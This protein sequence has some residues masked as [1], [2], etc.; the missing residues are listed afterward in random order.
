MSTHNRNDAV[1][2]LRSIRRTL[3][4]GSIVLTTVVSLA[5]CSAGT[6]TPTSSASAGGSGGAFVKSSAALFAKGSSVVTGPS[7]PSVSTDAIVPWKASLMPKP[8]ALPSKPV[9]VDVVFAIPVGYPPYVT[10]VIQTVGAKLGWSVK[11][12]QAAAPTQ[13]AALAS[14]QAAVL[15]KP[16]AIIAAVVPGVWIGPALSA[17]KAAGIPTIDLHQDSTTGPGYTA[18]V[19]D[20]EGVQKDLLAAYAVSTSKGTAHVLL[21]N[22]PGFSDANVPAATAYLKGCSGCSTSTVQFNPTDFLDPSTIQSDMT[23]KLASISKL[24]Y[25]VWP[26]GSI[27]TTT[28]VGALSASH[29]PKAKLLLNDASPESVG[30]VKK[31]SVPILVE[32][33]A[34]LTA[35]IGIDDVSRLVQGKAALGQSALRI[36]VSYWTAKT[37]PAANFGAMTTKQLAAAD[38]LTPFEKAWNKSLKST[39]LGIKG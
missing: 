23:A 14:M 5:A 30:L 10:H 37:A 24:D 12:F 3:T 33:P 25:V 18:W 13:P 6:A 9:R 31:G 20:A 16:D 22:S 1:R 26:N 35:L 36:P 4:V 39:I 38:W 29:T 7:F 11:V 28:V 32:M 17:A 8:V 21:A 2:R 34:A 19:P 27:P 15:D